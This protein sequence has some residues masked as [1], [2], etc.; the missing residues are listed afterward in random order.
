VLRHLAASRWVKL[1]LL[2]ITLGFCAYG[3]AAQRTEAVA[4]LQ[5]LSWAAVAGAL[6]AVLAG[7][8]CMMLS[9]RALL[10]DLGSPL[11]LRAATRVLFIAQL[12]KYVPG[13]VWAAA[14]QVELAREHLVPRKRAA[15]A[16]VVAMLVT[17]ASGLLV[18]AVALPLSSGDAAR[19]Y[20]WALAL[21]PPALIGLY[22]PV[23]CWVL[24]R[25]LRLAKRPPLERR[26]SGAGMIRAVAWALVAWAFFSVHAWLLVADMTGKGVSVLPIAAGAYALAWSVG[27]VLIP[28]PGG[29][30]PRELAFIAALAPVMPRGSAIVV[31]VVS[32][33]VLT[34]GDLA[35]AGAA[36][37]L[38]R[39]SR[40]G[41]GGPVRGSAAAPARSGAAAAT[42][43]DNAAAPAQNGAGG[44]AENG[45]AATAGSGGVTAPA[46]NSV[47]G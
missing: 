37:W 25:L 39:G 21:A 40:P 30:G 10:A 42:A 36:F 43:E 17:L 14:A 46:G 35:W 27:F 20:W 11:H 13:A 12:G 1:G 28:F 45:A 33:L 8:G 7:L 47:P 32:R 23:T 44:P 34:A 22:P 4:D 5:R 18:A 41:P 29:V 24:N 9:W 19:E 38:G 2:A 16:T 6:V 3:L 31:A 15:S 26:I